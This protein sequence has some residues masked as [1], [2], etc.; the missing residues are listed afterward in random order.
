MKAARVGLAA[1]WSLFQL[2]TA[3]AGL[4]DLLIQLPVHVAFAVGLGFLTPP[5]PSARVRWPDALGAALAL[6]CA[7]HYLYHHERLITRMAMVDDPATV[8]VVVGLLFVAL[9]L[10]ASRRHI[11]PALP[12]L[13]L[14][15]VA[16]AFVGP[17][18]P[19]FLSHGGEPFLK[20]VD[21]QM[22]TTGGVF[23]IPTL[24]SGTFIYLFVVFGGVM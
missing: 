22:F 14:A 15:F 20:L 19:G 1:V 24:V 18:L 6:A 2:Y 9:L 4:Y 11:G 16:Y 13:A 17:W 7:G 12:L 10:E 23:G 3:Q 21:Q 5:T 8:D